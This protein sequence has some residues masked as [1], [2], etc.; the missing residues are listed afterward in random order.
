MNREAAR[1]KAEALVSRMTLEEA[2]SQLIYNAP[3]IPRLNVPEYNWW[4]E[5]LHGV[6]RA[7]AATMFPQSIGLG[8][9]FDDE[10]VKE[11]GGIA[12]TEGRAKYN[13][14]SAHG[15]RDIY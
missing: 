4:N 5:A 1:Q 14:A 12:A 13:A 3:A 8:A 2:A 9:S 15:D 11:L 6:A 10:L 7:G